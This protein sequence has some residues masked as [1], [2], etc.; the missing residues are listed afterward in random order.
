[1]RIKG[2][3][4][5]S[6]RVFSTLAETHP[7]LLSPA[8]AELKEVFPGLPFGAIAEITGPACSGRSSLCNFYLAEATG[9]GYCCAFV[10]SRDCFDPHS[11]AAA[12]VNLACLLWVRCAGAEQALRAA[13]VLLHSGG[14]GVI[15][16]DLAMEPVPVLHRIPLS[17]WYRF[18]RAVEQTKTALLVV[19]PQPQLKSCASLA[20]DLAAVEPLWVG[21]HADFRILH[22]AHLTLQS[23]RPLRAQTAQL[24]ALRFA[25]PA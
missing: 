4:L 1:M 13:D 3:M 6:D 7:S 19:A 8:L 17:W 9:Q 18:R 2:E 24:K 20:A 14:W 11:A 25:S 12:G 5:Y 23:R 22:G 10:D 21:K 16:I 15:I